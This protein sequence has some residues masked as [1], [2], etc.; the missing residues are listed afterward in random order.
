M[1]IQGGDEYL[2]E[3]R[4]TAQLM[5]E[6]PVTASVSQ[7]FAMEQP[8]IRP[9][10]PW[11]LSAQTSSYGAGREQVD[12]LKMIADRRRQMEAKIIRT[13]WGE[14]DVVRRTSYDANMDASWV[15]EK[16]AS[17]ATERV[18]KAKAELDDMIEE[19]ERKKLHAERLQ[20]ALEEVKTIR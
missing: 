10:Q 13:D 1:P 6:I 20:E 18:R 7:T 15:M 4:M 16:E 12:V 11:D 14:A 17:E 19:A 9:A 2:Q 8:Q 5:A 3:A